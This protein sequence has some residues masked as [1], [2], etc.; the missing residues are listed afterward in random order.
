M[1][2]KAGVD[3]ANL[4][5]TVETYNGYCQT[6]VDEDFGRAP[7]NMQSLEGP[8]Y[9]VET[10]GGVKGTSGGLVIDES[11]RVLNEQDQPIPGL[12]AAGEICGTLA[13]NGN[14]VY[15]GGCFIICSSFG[16]IAAQNALTYVSEN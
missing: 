9:L 16:R 6:G 11:A 13:F 12:Y 14:C 7:E 4:A 8:F 15:N 1:A 3:P 10:I 5:A 2:E